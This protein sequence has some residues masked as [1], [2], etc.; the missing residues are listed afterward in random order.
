MPDV[1]IGAILLPGKSAPKILSR[2]HIALMPNNSVFVDVAIDQGGCSET[3]K[4]TTHSNPTYI[5]ENVIHYC[6]TNMPAVA[7]KTATLALE[8]MTFPYLEILASNNIE[9][10][11]R[12]NINF[13]N[14]L[15]IY[16]D[17]LVNK[18]VAESLNLEYSN[19]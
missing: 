17:K 2:E 7:A 9:D 15:N 4:P 13:R 11:C 3:S 8:Y 10:L 1:V 6:V 12:N 18:S 19:F 16:H 5:D 14:G